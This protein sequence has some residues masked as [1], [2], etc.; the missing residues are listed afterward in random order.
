MAGRNP[1]TRGARPSQL[2]AQAPPPMPPA[3]TPVA[4]TNVTPASAPVSTQ[5]VAP[6]PLASAS[7]ALAPVAQVPVTSN[8]DSMSRRE[9]FIDVC[10]SELGVS[11]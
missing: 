8:L 5:H 4:P 11:L 6:S 1:G 7:A 10:S 3:I 2:N 9:L